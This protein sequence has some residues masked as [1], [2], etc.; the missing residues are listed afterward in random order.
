MNTSLDD[1]IVQTYAG[2]GDF[3]EQMQQIP[4]DL[5]ETT[6][7]ASSIADVANEASSWTPAD[8]FLG[9]CVIVGALVIVA[10]FVR[11][12]P[13]GNGVSDLFMTLANIAK[14]KK[15]PKNKL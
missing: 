15:A 10:C 5:H 11:F 7:Y 6:E 8:W 12:T 13:F 4:M 14:K 3:P 9:A 1:I 2:G